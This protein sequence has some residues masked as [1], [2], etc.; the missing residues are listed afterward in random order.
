VTIKTGICQRCGVG[1]QPASGRQKF[2]LSCRQELDHEQD[3]KYETTHREET[4][5]RCHAWYVINRVEC[6][7]KSARFRI[8]HPEEK[9]ADD[10][11]SYQKRTFQR[12]L[13]AAK[14]RALKYDN[15]S[16]NELLTEVQWRELLTK[17]NGH[18]AYCGKEAKLTLDHVIPLSK[19]GK[20]SIDNVVPACKHCNSSK[21]A[22]TTEQWLRSLRAGNGCRPLEL[23]RAAGPCTGEEPS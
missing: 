19:G 1:Y 23:V 17:Y 14:H 6:L 21:Q 20:H 12:R 22:R 11:A 5:I 15:T 9:R 4:A 8:T 10:A 18:C 2:C 7:A 16:I 13:S 3:R